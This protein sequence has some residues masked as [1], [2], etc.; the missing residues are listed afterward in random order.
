MARLICVCV[1]LS[2]SLNIYFSVWLKTKTQKRTK[3]KDTQF[4]PTWKW[5]HKQAFSWSSSSSNVTSMNAY[6][7]SFYHVELALLYALFYVYIEL[8]LDKKK[9]MKQKLWATCRWLNSV[10]DFLYILSVILF[11]VAAVLSSLIFFFSN[12]FFGDNGRERPR[13]RERCAFFFWKQQTNSIYHPLN[14]NR[15]D[16]MLTHLGS[17]KV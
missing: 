13:E 10:N 7:E 4:K 1:F 11:L 2:V 5:A 12:L 16:S 14:A 15:Y 6:D 3:K 9:E 8:K 17:K